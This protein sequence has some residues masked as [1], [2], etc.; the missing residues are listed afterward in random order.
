MWPF[1]P[2]LSHRAAIVVRGLG[3]L[4]SLAM[5]G[6]AIAWGSQQ[7]PDTIPDVVFFANL[8]RSHTTQPV[9][10][11]RIPP[12]GGAHRPVWQNCGRYDEPIE[13]AYAVHSLEHGAV[14]IAYRPDLPADV[15][16]ELRDLLNGQTYM[17]L[18]PYPDLAAP[19]VVSVWGAQLQVDSASDPRLPWFITKYRQG[20]QTP[21]PDATCSDG[22]GVPVARS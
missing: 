2:A 21:E 3:I 4:A 7:Q 19:V 18:S 5:I 9:I 13:N 12:A 14:W 11:P 16:A 1:P 8:P 15:L 20:A 6:V 10:Y 22:V 17:L